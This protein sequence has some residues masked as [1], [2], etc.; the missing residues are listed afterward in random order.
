M[1][2]WMYRR[3]V[4]IDGCLRDQKVCDSV[5]TSGVRRDDKRFSVML[6]ED[7]PMTQKAEGWA[8]QGATRGC[9][10]GCFSVSTRGKLKLLP[11]R[12]E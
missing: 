1:P 11:G 5:T 7:T 4:N 6:I 9:G 2:Q 10:S 12:V 3:S 8:G